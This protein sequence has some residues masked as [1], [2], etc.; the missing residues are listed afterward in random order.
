MDRIIADPEPGVWQVIVENQDLMVPGDAETR[1]ARF[2]LTATVFGAES[3]SPPAEFNTRVREIL[4]KQQVRFASHLASFDGYYAESPLGSAFSTRTNLADLDEPIVYEI[5]VPQGASTLRAGID[6]QSTKAADV[7][8]YLY[9]CANQCELKAFSARSGVQ[10]QVIIAQP[11]GGKWKV[12]IDPV[13]IASGTLT[14][15]YTDVFTHTAFGSLTPLSTNIAFTKGTNADTDFAAEIH[16]LPVN[17]R[18]LVGLVE[19][20]TREPATVRYEYNAVT[21]KFER[22][23]ERVTL[24]EALLE[25]HNR[26]N[27]L[28]PLT[29]AAGR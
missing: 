29:G 20:M 24:A 25:L 9:F 27:K 3:K 19:L 11:K 6:S 16:A 14:L 5:N 4:N 10:E 8:L 28:K 22:V 2:R 17:G 21:K 18:R 12:V 23:K 1:R 13:S 7:D 15:D 26:V